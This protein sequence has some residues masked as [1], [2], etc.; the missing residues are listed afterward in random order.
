MVLTFYPT[1][2][3]D[4]CI[5]HELS[6]KTTNLPQNSEQHRCKNVAEKFK[7]VKSEKIKNV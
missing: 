3:D 6:I 2:Y 5:R 4:T 1:Y 7:N